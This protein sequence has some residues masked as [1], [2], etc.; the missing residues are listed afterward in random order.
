MRIQRMQ[1]SQGRLGDKTWIPRQATGK[2][3]RGC[4]RLKRPAKWPMAAHGVRMGRSQR[5]SGTQENGFLRWR[6]CRCS[7]RPHGMHR[8]FGFAALFSPTDRGLMLLVAA[9]M[10]ASILDRPVLRASAA[11]RRCMR[12]P[13]NLSLPVLLGGD[14]TK[15]AA[16]ALDSR[17]PV[18]PSSL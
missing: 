14:R 8:H 7:Q 13:W 6:N 4:A 10:S 15:Q 3:A 2:D 9:F 1:C 5:R 16:A 18:A 12:G 11:R 17:V